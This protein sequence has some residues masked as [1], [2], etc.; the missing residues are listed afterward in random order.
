MQFT[1]FRAIITSERSEVMLENIKSPQD[2]KSLTNAECCE[3][4]SE[5]RDK[6]INTVSENG[7]HLA[8]NLGMVEATIVLHR[9]FDSP[10]D[11]LIFDVGHQCYA[12]KLLTGRLDKFDTIRKYS[13]LSGFTSPAESKHDILYAGH[14]GTSV[15]AALGIA[16]AEKLRHGDNAPY[17]VAIVG[18]GSM[19]NG[20]IYEALNNCADKNLNLIILVNDNEMSISQNVGGLHNYL[21]RIRTSKGYFNLK[22]G[23]ERFLSRI[24]LIGMPS[25]KLLKYLKDLI[26]HMFVS[27]TIFEDLGL[28]YLGPVDGHDIKRLSNVLDEA[29]SKHRCCIVHMITQKGKGFVPAENRPDK[30]HGVGN[31][32]IVTGETSAPAETPFSAYFGKCLTTLAEKDSEICAVTA[33][34]SEGTGLTEFAKAFPDRFFDV[35]IAEEHAVTFAGGLSAMGMKPVVALYSTFAQRVCDQLIHDVS[36]QNLSLTLAL[37][38]CGLVPGDGVTHQ[39]IFDYSLFSS[40][41]NTEIYSISKASQLEGI[42]SASVNRKGLTV[43]RYPKISTEELDYSEDLI[44]DGFISCTHNITTAKKVIITHG[45]LTKTALSVS[46]ELTDVSVI[47]LVRVFP[48]DYDKIRTLIAKCKL[49]Y[50][51]DEGITSGGLSEKLRSG[52]AGGGNYDIIIRA[53]DSFS[54]HGSIADL[55]KSHGFTKDHILSDLTS[56]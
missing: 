51:L 11:K 49:V 55:M 14:S 52:L 10:K 2:I 42:L 20:M 5:L 38:R 23:F 7:G 39:G 45:R 4:A 53:I 46:S 13:G 43:I 37:D 54:T 56:I 17:T 12:H 9:L 34:M 16:S 22:R 29:K 26:K 48:V 3:L 32:D 36:I 35:G 8:S 19:T 24:P 47:S 21:S 27:D 18:D 25:A 50:I 15:S 6:I 31:F 1:T 30:F 33:A 44:T 40:I 41:P 28:I